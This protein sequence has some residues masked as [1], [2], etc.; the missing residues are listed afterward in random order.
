VV[1]LLQDPFYLAGSSRGGI[2]ANEARTEE[3]ADARPLAA[4]QLAQLEAVERGVQGKL[5]EDNVDVVGAQVIEGRRRGR[6][7]YNSV[8]V[9]L[10]NGR[11]HAADGYVVVDNENLLHSMPIVGA[12]GMPDGSGMHP[13]CA[14]FSR[15]FETR[16]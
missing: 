16:P 14:T 6:D 2:E 8:P 9:S 13:I 3:T 4:N 7:G 10:E 15:L 1:G 11:Q 12:P 5:R